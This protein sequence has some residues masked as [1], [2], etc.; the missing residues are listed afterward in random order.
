MIYHIGVACI[1]L[2]TERRLIPCRDMGEGIEKK[3]KKT[4]LDP[5]TF[6]PFDPNLDPV[7]QQAVVDCFAMLRRRTQAGLLRESYYVRKSKK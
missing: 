4:P 1:T 7:I 5:K 3:T 2:T 6:N